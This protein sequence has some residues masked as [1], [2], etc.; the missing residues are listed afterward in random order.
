M[1]VRS[2]SAVLVTLSAPLASL[3]AQGAPQQARPPE[4]PR[5]RF[6]GPAV[7]GRIASVAG[8]AGDSLTLYFG[9]ASGGVWKTS[10][11]GPAFNRSM[12]G[13]L[14]IAEKVSP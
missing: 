12:A 14:T 1:R 8:V 11:G 6:M 9:A 7:G 2:L 13:K 4:P 10:D 5:F 3:A